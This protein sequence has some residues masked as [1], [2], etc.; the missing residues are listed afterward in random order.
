MIII[1]L[2]IHTHILILSTKHLLSAKPCARHS[3]NTNILTEPLLKSLCHCL[4]KASNYL[5]SQ[6][7]AENKRRAHSF[8]PSK[9]FRNQ[10][11][12][13]SWR[14]LPTA[15]LQAAAGTQPALPLE[16]SCSHLLT[17]ADPSAELHSMLELHVLSLT[18]I[19]NVFKR[20]TVWYRIQTKSD[21][22]NR[23]AWKWQRSTTLLSGKQIFLVGRT[24]PIQYLR[25]N[26]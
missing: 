26:R 10:E 25:S 3:R 6:K 16:V 21:Y 1:L 8:F 4:K 2:P 23:N 9:I 13:C 12:H 15:L 18:A 19:F 20:I 7:N 14:H 17:L 24:P 22:I 11:V 5:F